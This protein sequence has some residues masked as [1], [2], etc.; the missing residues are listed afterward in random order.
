MYPN[1]WFSKLPISLL[2]FKEAK[3]FRKRLSQ[4]MVQ[5]GIGM[6]TLKQWHHVIVSER[7]KSEIKR[8]LRLE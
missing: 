2:N 3:F 4:V 1:Q 8:S 6:P 7:S 5:V